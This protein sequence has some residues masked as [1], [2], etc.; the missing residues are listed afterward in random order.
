MFQNEKLST[1]QQRA[2]AS[3]SNETQ[4]KRMRETNQCAIDETFSKRIRVKLNKKTLENACLELVTING[5]PF[6]IMTDF[7][8]RKILNPLLEGMQANFNIN[9]NNI[10][11]KIGVK[12]NDVRYRIKLEVEHR[13]VS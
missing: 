1:L 7:G 2:G 10:Q 12:A 11:E 4:K 13:L 8:F 3:F 6:K 5:C 9:A